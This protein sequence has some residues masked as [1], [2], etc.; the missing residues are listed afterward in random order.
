MVL[1]VVGWNPSVFA[2][3]EECRCKIHV[4]LGRS[5][6][7]YDDLLSGA[8]ACSLELTAGGCASVCL[9]VCLSVSL[10]LFKCLSCLCPSVC[11]FVCL[12]LSVSVS[13]SLSLSVSVCLSVCL[14]VYLSVSVSLSLLPLSPSLRPVSGLIS[15]KAS[16]WSQYRL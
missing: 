11:M 7:S 5:G 4:S 14:S 9:S 1:G 13:L 12:C 6:S 15:R 8:Y 10:S 3:L 16:A 2:G